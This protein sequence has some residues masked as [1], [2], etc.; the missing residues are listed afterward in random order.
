M[1]EPYD[2]VHYEVIEAEKSLWEINE[3]F[4]LTF[5]EPS[6]FSTFANES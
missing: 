5:S 3:A 2:E 1:N 4:T 6:S